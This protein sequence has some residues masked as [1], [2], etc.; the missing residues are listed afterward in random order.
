VVDIIRPL[1]LYPK[2]LLPLVMTMPA[3]L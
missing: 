1:L 2:V 3:A